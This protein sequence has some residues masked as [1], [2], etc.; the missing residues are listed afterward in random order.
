MLN[1]QTG[2]KRNIFLRII[3]YVA[4]QK[5][6]YRSIEEVYDSLDSFV[7]YY[8]SESAHNGRCSR[9]RIQL[10]TFTDWLWIGRQHTLENVIEKMEATLS[11]GNALVESKQSKQ[12]IIAEV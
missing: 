5:K 7:T 11:G 10:Q 8:S 12:F 4:F 6:L 3:I 2:Q 9:G 1:N